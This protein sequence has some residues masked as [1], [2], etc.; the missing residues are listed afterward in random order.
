MNPAV[1]ELIKP[2]PPELWGQHEELK[3]LSKSAA[4]K[5]KVCAEQAWYVRIIEN[6]ATAAWWAMR[7]PTLEHVTA[8][9][10]ALDVWD[11]KL[12]Y[13]E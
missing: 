13:K 5:L 11:E 10:R 1:Q 12:G 2:L 7:E 3:R 4:R 8:L 6:V 9:K